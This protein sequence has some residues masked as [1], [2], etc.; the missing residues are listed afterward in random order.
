MNSSDGGK[1]LT[2][3]THASQDSQLPE[4]EKFILNTSDGDEKNKVIHFLEYQ[5]GHLYKYIHALFD[6]IMFV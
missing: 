3:F 4:S 2:S 5:Y 1:Q 6:H